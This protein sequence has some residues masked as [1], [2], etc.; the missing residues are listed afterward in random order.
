M[1]LGILV[2][3]K[4]TCVTLL[5]VSPS[6][7][8]SRFRKVNM[9]EASQG[10]KKHEL[11]IGSLFSC[12]SWIAGRTL[13]SKLL[14]R[15]QSCRRGCPD[16]ETKFEMNVYLITRCRLLALLY[17]ISGL[18]AAGEG[19]TKDCIVGGMLGRLPLKGIVSLSSKD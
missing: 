5:C 9:I 11:L 10:H 14:Y 6:L 13:F 1:Q 12:I 17:V 3:R 2:N 15:R 7:G 18:G 8:Y 4:T 16:M 19:I